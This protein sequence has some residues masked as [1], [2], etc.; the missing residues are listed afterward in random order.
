MENSRYVSGQD[1]TARNAFGPRAITDDIGFLVAYLQ[2][3]MSLLDCGW[4]TGI[5]RR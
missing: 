2:A 4:R 3:G 5:D 1:E